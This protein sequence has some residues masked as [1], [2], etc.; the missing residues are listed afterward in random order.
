MNKIKLINLDNIYE[1]VSEMQNKDNIVLFD[2]LEKH[3]ELIGILAY[4]VKL[5]YHIAIFLLE[6]SMTVRIGHKDYT[7]KSHDLA[8]VLKGKI[9]QPLEISNDAKL[10]I[11]CINEDFF[12]IN[13]EVNKA[14]EI[15]NRLLTN[16]IVNLSPGNASEYLATFK[17]IKKYQN[18][19]KH[20]CRIEII[21]N[22]CF[23]IFNLICDE[24]IKEKEF[25]QH[26]ISRKETIY[27]SFI[28]N[29]EKHYKHERSVKFYADKL[30]LTPKYL[31]SVIHQVSGKHASE[32]LDDFIMLEIKALL[33]TTNMPIQQI[34]YELNFSTPAHFG[35]FFK[36]IT[37]VSPKRYRQFI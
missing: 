29:I 33:K 9:Y 17:N 6:G 1:F 11:C 32:W 20:T 12:D 31:S 14:C 2:N 4:P 5:N 37:G 35:K 13:P 15:Y 18:E 23:I 24:L 16:P 25:I 34:A 21:K 26:N 3:H 19:I 30:C 28:S 7:L 10:T 8:Y 22:Y 36:R 27:Q